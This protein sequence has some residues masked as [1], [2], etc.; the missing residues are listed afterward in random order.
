MRAPSRERASALAQALVDR[1]AFAV[2]SLAVAV[3]VIGFAGVAATR[4]DVTGGA[5]VWGSFWL[6]VAEADAAIRNP[7]LALLALVLLAVTVLVA[8]VRWP[9]ARRAFDGFPP[10]RRDLLRLQERLK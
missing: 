9:K 2:E 7:M 10:S 3:M 5:Y 6:R 1:I 4:F 8:F